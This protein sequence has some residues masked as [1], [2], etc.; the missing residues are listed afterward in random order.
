MDEAGLLSL[1]AI[2][3]ETLGV[4]PVGGCERLRRRSRARSLRPG[5]DQGEQVVETLKSICLIINH[6]LSTFVIQF[7]QLAPNRGGVKHVDAPQH[8][9]FF[10][11]SRRTLKKVLDSIDQGLQL[12]GPACAH[13]TES[14]HVHAHSWEYP[15]CLERH[16]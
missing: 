4:S 16:V 11:G 14:D 9:V 5:V 3:P 13:V 1:A 15:K 2:A 7:E 12:L 8:A 10:R 6:V